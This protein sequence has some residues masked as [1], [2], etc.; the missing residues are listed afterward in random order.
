MGEDKGIQ[1]REG[2]KNPKPTEESLK[3]ISRAKYL[4]FISLV[5]GVIYCLQ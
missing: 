1:I 3:K 4:L 2:E 5:S